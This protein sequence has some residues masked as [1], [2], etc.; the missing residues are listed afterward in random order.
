VAA[1]LRGPRD[2]QLFDRLEAEH[3]NLRAAL[4]WCEA[5]TGG[6]DAAV[7]IVEGLAWFWVLRNHMREASA[8]V[9]RLITADSGSA[10]TRATLYCVAGYLAYFR[11]AH[12]E[13]LRWLEPSLALWRQLD[14]RRGLAT[15][16]TYLAQAAWATGD[17][18]RAAPLLEESV[19]LV[20]RAEA[21]TPQNAVLATHAEPPFQS[22]ARFA[23]E[24]GDLDRAAQLLDE[25][26]M[27]SRQR[28]AS[29][30]VANA[31][32]TM[33]M[34]ACRGGDVERATALLEES[35]RLFHEL[36][37]VPCSWNQL[38]LVAHVAT[39][40]GRHTRAARLLGAADVQQR[41]SGM[42][43][44]VI[45]RAVHQDTITATRSVLGEDAFAAAWAEGRA[46]TLEQA[47]AYALGE[48]P[49][50]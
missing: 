50:A 34:H 7:P 31:L 29:H 22:L 20:R 35:L 26:L 25:S 12:E 5:E 3:G 11:G 13:A 44:L 30:G 36:A 27:F 39:K 24:Q 49:P 40:A 43:P 8:R 9:Q 4:D 48:Q 21:G 28:G 18:A 47:V 6:I 42:V 16:L 37:D 19:D 1:E 45:A 38:V 46:M 23:E 14:D 32:R 17:R 2:A 15:A 33:A 10:A 41:A